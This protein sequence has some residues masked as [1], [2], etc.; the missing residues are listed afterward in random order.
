[1]DVHTA[2]PAWLNAH[3]SAL[4]SLP[5]GGLFL[6]AFTLKYTKSCVV[7]SN[8]SYHWWGESYRAGMKRS[9]WNQCLMTRLHFP[10]GWWAA[11]H[12]MTAWSLHCWLSTVLYSVSVLNWTSC[13]PYVLCRLISTCCVEIWDTLSEVT[14]CYMG[15]KVHKS[16][17]TSIYPEQKFT[18]YYSLI[19]A[20]FRIDE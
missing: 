2:G 13:E 15:V 12:L 7:C 6:V 10:T 3:S 9:H 17:G 14:L 18:I 20:F 16:R 1:M 11:C 4:K 8:I 19:M 5:S